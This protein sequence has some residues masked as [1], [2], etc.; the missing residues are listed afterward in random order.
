MGKR[1][2]VS[3]DNH[4]LDAKN[5]AIISSPICSDM[6]QKI[7]FDQMDPYETLEEEIEDYE[8][9]IKYIKPN[10]RPE[11]CYGSIEIISGLPSSFKMETFD[12]IPSDDPYYNYPLPFGMRHLLSIYRQKY[13]IDPKQPF[14][15]L[16]STQSNVLISSESSSSSSSEGETDGIDTKS[17]ITDD[18]ITNS[19]LTSDSISKC[20]LFDILME[21]R[22]Q[23]SK[24]ASIDKIGQEDLYIGLEHVI[25]VLKNYTPYCQPF[26]VK[27][28]R[29]EVPDYYLIINQPMDLGTMAKKLRRL[30]YSS[31]KEFEA[32]LKLIYDNCMFY[33]TREDSIYRSYVKTLMEKA[34]QLLAQVPDITIRSRFDE[35]KVNDT[36]VDKKLLEIASTVQNQLKMER[37]EKCMSSSFT[38]FKPSIMPLKQHIWTDSSGYAWNIRLPIDSEVNE[39]LSPPSISM[40]LGQYY[41]NNKIEASKMSRRKDNPLFIQTLQKSLM[42]LRSIHNEP[43]ISI[44]FEDTVDIVHNRYSA[45][46]YL[47]RIL[48]L[49]LSF[50]GFTGFKCK[51]L[52]F[53]GHLVEQ[54]IFQT[55]YTIQ[56]Y[57]SLCRNSK[58][59]A[60]TENTLLFVINEMGMDSIS[61]IYD[62]LRWFLIKYPMRLEMLNNV[63][64]KHLEL[65]NI[66][67]ELNENTDVAFLGGTFV[68]DGVEEEL[69]L[70]LLGLKEMGLSNVGY[71]PSKLLLSPD[72]NRMS[73]VSI[74]AKEKDISDPDI[75]SVD[76]TLQTFPPKELPYMKIDD[77]CIGLLNEY[78]S[79]APWKH[80]GSIYINEQKYSLEPLIIPDQP[81]TRVSI[82]GRTKPS[83]LTA[84]TNTV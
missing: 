64:Q 21:C 65:D 79:N 16:Y 52:S 75:G 73:V 42:I 66:E 58:Y 24:W 10:I 25:H 34:S 59:D 23:R 11:N 84:P 45:T 5:D 39:S 6:S 8:F 9:Y 81:Q 62:Y 46:I 82:R 33:N 41:I 74:W 68:Y 35:S 57:Q 28:N 43:A 48:S 19:Q 7:L 50:S 72:H 76:T 67:N 80:D 2:Y 30:A 26:N 60:T 27:V 37:I 32:D 78:Y 22:P 47:H 1:I 17:E 54:F 20:S 63:M 36:Q 18:D 55:C 40:I 77:Q 70:D 56:Y 69:G 53:L 15:Q 38:G 71:V 49:L 51:A 31:K 4:H 44:A 12:I 13:N 83:I 29:R 61:D 3:H 14:P